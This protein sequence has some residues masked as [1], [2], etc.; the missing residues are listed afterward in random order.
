MRKW[1]QVMQVAFTYI[2]TIVGAGFASGQE[3]LQFFTQYGRVAALTIIVATIFFIWLGIKVMLLAK[4]IGAQSYEVL[5]TQLFGDLIGRWISFFMMIILLGTS[6]VML[7]GAGSLFAEQLNFSYQS[8]LLLTLILSYLVLSNGIQAIMRVNSLVVPLML[9]FTAIVVFHTWQMPNHE[10]WLKL[11][12][13]LPL[14][15]IWFSPI[16][17]AAFNLAGAQAVLVPLGNTIEDRSILIW[18]GVF[19]GIGIGLMLLA[20]HFALSAQMPGIQQFEIPM[21]HI[22]Q[23]LGKSI[24]LIYIFVIFGEIFTTYI[25]GLY[26]LTL[27]LQQKTTLHPRTLLLILLIISYVISQIGFSMLLSTLYPLF[28]SVSLIWFVMIIYRR[29]LI[30]NSNQP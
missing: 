8:G 12:S 5:N 9:I 3:I 10:S 2:G 1:N 19:G 21:G 20:A 15:R 26:G 25:A 14:A 23:H 11:S 7:A 30:M 16:V 18:G 4:S 22:I 17:Y 24:Q 29:K 13:D 28:G 27:Q 6:A